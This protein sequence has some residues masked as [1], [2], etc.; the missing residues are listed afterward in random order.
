[1]EYN[2]FIPTS[3]EADLTR[4]FPC[5]CRGPSMYARQ[6]VYEALKD[7]FDKNPIALPLMRSG[8][9]LLLR[10]YTVG[11]ACLKDYADLTIRLLRTISLRNTAPPE[12]F[13]SYNQ[14]VRNLLYYFYK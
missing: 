1:M 7:M 8:S 3:S 9:P 6:C 14:E 12:T 13:E 11:C 10:H 5:S 4:T 2:L